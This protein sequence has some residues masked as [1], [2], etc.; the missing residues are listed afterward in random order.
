[1]RSMM[2]I[3]KKNALVVFPT[4][5]LADIDG[6]AIVPDIIKSCPTR[7]RLPDHCAI[8]PQIMVI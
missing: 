7:I 3:R 4:Q 5:S 6:S 8:E 2:P 1:M